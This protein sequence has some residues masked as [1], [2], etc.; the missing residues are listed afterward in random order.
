MD[1]GKIPQYRGKNKMFSIDIRKCR[2]NLLI[3]EK[4][5]FCVYSC[6]DDIKPFDVNDEIVNG[7]YY[8][9]SDVTFPLRM[10]GYK[11][12]NLVKFCLNRK[13]IKKSNIKFKWI[14]SFSLNSDYFVPII[15]Y[16]LK[17]FE[18]NIEDTQKLAP[19]SLVGLFGR[20]ENSYFDGYICDRKNEHDM[21]NAMTENP[22]SF[23]Y[24]INEDLC[25]VTS[26]LETHKLE[27]AYPIYAQ[28][29]D[30]E[31]MEL[32]KLVEIVES[33]GGIPICIK[34][35]AVVYFSKKKLI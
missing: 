24:N 11:H 16:L 31:A 13:I 12:S 29:L 34:T 33:K 28:I 23:M 2:R 19:N 26:K 9:E 27:N 6:L 1:E 32:Y 25:C 17:V 3:Q 14:P 30:E 22:H 18:E 35:D 7:F 15:D 20:R 4:K 5:Q 8:I 10:N 21:A